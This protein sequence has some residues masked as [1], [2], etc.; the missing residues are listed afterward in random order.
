MSSENSSGNF[1]LD[2]GGKIFSAAVIGAERILLESSSEES[3]SGSFGPSISDTSAW[4]ATCTSS[5][6]SARLLS[7]GGRGGAFFATFGLKLTSH[8]TRRWSVE[9][10]VCGDT[11]KRD[12]KRMCEAG[13]NT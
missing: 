4:K 1:P 3:C 7:C 13:T 11:K 5:S 8:T 9:T 10:V 6:Y 2:C 12:M